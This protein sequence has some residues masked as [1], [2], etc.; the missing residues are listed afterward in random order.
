[1]RPLINKISLFILLILLQILIIDKINLGKLSSYFCPLIYG[2]L[3]IIL[4]PKTNIFILFLIAFSTG[5]IID[6]FRD[7]PGLNAS[8]LLLVAFVKKPLLD[9]MFYK[10]DIDETKD[11][12]IYSLGLSKFLI[13]A[14]ILLFIQHIWF[15]II[16]YSS[17]YML[18]NV[19]TK[20]IVNSV[21]A[22]LI[23][24]IIQYL[25]VNYKH[26]K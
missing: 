4:K 11:I 3:I 24:L 25:F 10:D 19:I 20:S 13:F 12:N 16:E 21:L 26:N 15:Y 5:I 14:L 9:L 6:I 1:M 23:L 18:T 2:F 8:A 22:T 7:T 17:F